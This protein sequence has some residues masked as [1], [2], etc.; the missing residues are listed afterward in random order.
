MQAQLELEQDQLVEHI[1]AKESTL[2]GLRSFASVRLYDFDERRTAPPETLFDK[3]GRTTVASGGRE[4]VLETPEDAEEN[5][6]VRAI[7]DDAEATCFVYLS[8]V[9]HKLNGVWTKAGIE[10]E[11]KSIPFVDPVAANR[12][13]RSVE[14]YWNHNYDDAAHLVTPTI[15]RVLRSYAYLTRAIVRRAPV[16]GNDATGAL[17][18]E[19]LHKLQPPQLTEHLNE[20][21]RLLLNDM[22][23]L[24]LRNGLSHGELGLISENK[25][26]MLI[27]AALF[28][29]LIVVHGV[30]G[31]EE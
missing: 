1:K 12:I 21:L 20:W 26:A 27:Q 16:P 4:Q 7:T 24:N 30:Q 11:L 23:G 2:D 10:A 31:E 9:L 22:P 19:L 8:P 5:R 25:A 28:P 18:T 15:E 17:L 13:A 14:H 3:L 29:S 6:R